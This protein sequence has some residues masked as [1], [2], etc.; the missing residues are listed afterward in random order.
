MANENPTRKTLIETTAKLLLNQG[1]N[2]TGLN[3]ITQ[4]SGAPKGSLYYHFPEGKEQLAC[5]AIHYT[6]TRARVGLENALQSVSDPVEAVQKVLEEII[7][8]FEQDEPIGIPIG[9][10]AHET[11]K[12]NDTIRQACNNAYECWGLEFRKKF[13]SAGYPEEE[14]QELATMINAIIEGSI[15]MSLTQQSSAPLRIASKL[16]PKLFKK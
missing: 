12:S 11:A 15:I 10:V 16:V 3:Q 1:Y 14:A 7:G 5:E 4:L 2:A 13:V 8:H 6:Q 9:I